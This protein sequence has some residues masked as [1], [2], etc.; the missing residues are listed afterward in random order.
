MGLFHHLRILRKRLADAQGVAP[1]VVFH[2]STLLAMTQQRPQSKEQFAKIPGVGVSKLDAY[3]TPFTGAIRDYCELHNLA[4]G[5]EPEPQKMEAV[6]ASRVNGSSPTCLLTL[7]LYKQGQNIRE[8]ARE[9]NLSPRT[10]INHLTEL[11]EGGEAVDVESLIQPG[12]YE[13]IVDALQQIGSELLKP[14]KEFLGDEY[15]Y[16]EIQLVRAAMRSSS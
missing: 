13:I 16:E 14:I 7:E 8:I 15:S 10:V 3:L 5:L 4:M 11:I 9:R 6:S 12:H 2:D 1:F